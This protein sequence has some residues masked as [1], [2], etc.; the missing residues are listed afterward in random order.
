MHGLDV[1]CN[2]IIPDLDT[3]KNTLFSYYKHKMYRHYTQKHNKYTHVRVHMYY[4]L[5]CLMCDISLIKTL[6]FLR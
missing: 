2:L 5:V 3:F 4:R 6:H 1:G